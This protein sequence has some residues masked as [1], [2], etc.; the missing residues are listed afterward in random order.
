[1]VSKLN[2]GGFSIG[3]N[4]FYQTGSTIYIRI[5]WS[6]LNVTDPSTKIVLNDAGTL[7]DQ[8]KTVSTN[9]AIVSVLIADKAT[10][11]QL[12][13]FPQTKQDPSYKTFKWDAWE[14]CEYSLREKEG[15]AILAKYFGSK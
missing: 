1:L 12:Y 13:L 5:P 3:D 15:Y 9:G 6:W 4:Q 11:D 8:A 7:G 14:K 10:K 2:Y